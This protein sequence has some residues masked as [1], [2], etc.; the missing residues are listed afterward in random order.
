ML[1]NLV[2]L[3]RIQELSVDWYRKDLEG[4]SG[5]DKSL[6]ALGFQRLKG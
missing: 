1:K 6:L 4:I 5:M 3:K 2:P